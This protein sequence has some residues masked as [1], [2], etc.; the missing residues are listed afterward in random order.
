MHQQHRHL[1][2]GV[3]CGLWEVPGLLG[4]I[5]LIF[6]TRNRLCDAPTDNPYGCALPSGASPEWLIRLS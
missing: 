2:W 3:S 1:P 4:P 5:Y 6:K